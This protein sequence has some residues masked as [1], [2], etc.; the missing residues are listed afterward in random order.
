MLPRTVA[1][2]GVGLPVVMSHPSCAETDLDSSS[3]SQ[4]S[5]SQSQ[6]EVDTYVTG[7]LGVDYCTHGSDQV[8]KI[9]LNG[10]N[11]LLDQKGLEKK[12]E[13]DRRREQNQAGQFQSTLSQV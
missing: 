8:Y 4:S 5:S 11:K 13:I 7:W 9:G 1:A 3:S 12:L 10:C 2:S 6:S